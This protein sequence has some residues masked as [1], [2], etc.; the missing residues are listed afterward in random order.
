MYAITTRGRI[1]KTITK[2][3]LDDAMKEDEVMK[4]FFWSHFI[5]IGLNYYLHHKMSTMYLLCSY[6]IVKHFCCY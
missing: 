1:F 5:L 2:A 6:C 3:K 4:Y